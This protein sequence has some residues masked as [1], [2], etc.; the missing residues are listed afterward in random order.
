MP[1]PSILLFT[2]MSAITQFEHH[3]I[4][5]RTSEGGDVHPVVHKQECTDFNPRSPHGE[6]LALHVSI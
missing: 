1:R 3:V 2:L 4:A 5:E 6:R